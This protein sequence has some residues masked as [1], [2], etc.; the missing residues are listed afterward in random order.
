MHVVAACGHF[1]RRVFGPNKN[2]SPKRDVLFI[3]I[4]GIKMLCYSY[5]GLIKLCNVAVKCYGNVL[6]QFC[7]GYL[8]N[9]GPNPAYLGWGTKAY[10]NRPGH[11]TKLAIMPIY[12]KSL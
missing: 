9:L 4:Y 5:Q 2:C 6:L 1:S 3:N 11:M 10:S 7:L 12:G 8:F